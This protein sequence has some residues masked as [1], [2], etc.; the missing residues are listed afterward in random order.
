MKKPTLVLNLTGPDGNVF[1]VLGRAINTLKR[2]GMEREA[3]ELSQCYHQAHSYHEVL[4][5]VREYVDLIDSSEQFPE[6]E[7]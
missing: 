2:N 4:K 3:G 1:I 6:E 5:I 7:V